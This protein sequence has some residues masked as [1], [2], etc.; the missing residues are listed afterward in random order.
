MD[1]KLIDYTPENMEEAAAE[2]YAKSKEDLKT[3][4]RS[5]IVRQ[6]TIAAVDLSIRSFASTVRI[7]DLD[8]DAALKAQQMSVACGV[9]AMD[10]SSRVADLMEKDGL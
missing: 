6:M 4:S 8:D 1:S 9:C 3:R 2:I 5:W 7:S 10:I